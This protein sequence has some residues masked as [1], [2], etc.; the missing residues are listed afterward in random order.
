MQYSYEDSTGYNFKRC[1]TNSKQCSYNVSVT[2]YYFLYFSH[3]FP[4]APQKKGVVKIARGSLLLN[5]Y[6]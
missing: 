5:F 3:Y 4:L 2:Y 1:L 6:Y